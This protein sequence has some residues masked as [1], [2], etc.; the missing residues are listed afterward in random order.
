MKIGGGGKGRGKNIYKK[1]KI[2]TSDML[3]RIRIYISID[4]R[5]RTGGTLFT[6]FR[7]RETAG[8]EN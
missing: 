7:G 6:A 2:Y 1:K 4:F 5:Y 8:G 3:F